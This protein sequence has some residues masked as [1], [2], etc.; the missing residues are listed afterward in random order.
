MASI[1]LLKTHTL[2]IT[3]EGNDTD[4]GRYDESGKWINPTATE[5]FDVI[6]NLQSYKAANAQ[7]VLPEGTRT[8]DVKIFY[9]KEDLRTME[10]FNNLPAD[11]ATIN[12]KVYTVFTELDWTEFNLTPDHRAYIFLMDNPR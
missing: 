1:K 7:K 12:S 5:D 2:T 4:K 10:Q 3:R 11:K 8:S 6:G 9:T